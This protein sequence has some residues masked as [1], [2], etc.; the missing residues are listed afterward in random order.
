MWIGRVRTRLPVAWNTAFAIA[1]AVPIRAIS[2]TP[3]TPSGYAFDLP[4]LNG[5]DLRSARQ[6]ERKAALENRLDRIEAPV[7]RAS[8][9]SV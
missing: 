5:F 8:S 9:Y 6:I 7:V 1:G 3:F 2:P 4:Y